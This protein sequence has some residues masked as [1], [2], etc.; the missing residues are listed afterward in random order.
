MFRSFLSAAG[1][2]ALPFLGACVESTTEPASLTS[3]SITNLGL[4]SAPGE[5]AGQD[6]LWLFAAREFDTGGRDLNRDGD[7]LDRIVYVQDLGSG[8]ARSTGLALDTRGFAPQLAVGDDL[9]AFAASES[10]GGGTDLN[11]DGD[12]ND[13]V[14]FA[15]DGATG[16]VQ[17]LA[18]AV[19][20]LGPPAVGDGIAAVLVSEAAQGK[21]DL[22]GDGASDDDVLFVFDRGRRELLNARIAVSSPLFAGDGR[23]AYFQAESSTDLN[24]DGDLLDRAVLQVYDPATDT[25]FNTGLATIGSEPLEA[26]GAWLVSV[27]EFEQGFDLNADA[28]LDDVVFVVFD[29]RANFRLGGGAPPGLAPWTSLGLVSAG[30]FAAIVSSVPAGSE[31]FGLLALEAGDVDRNG[32]GDLVDLVAFLYDP[33]TDQL[34]STARAAVRI[35][36]AGEWLGFLQLESTGVSGD[37]PSPDL[38]G[39]GDLLDAVAC[40]LNPLT[41]GITNLKQDAFDLVGSEDDVLLLL[42]PESGSN[43]DWNGDGDRDD[44]V[45]HAYDRIARTTTN[46]LL[47]VAGAF[48]ATRSE[49]LLFADEADQSR[50]LDADGDRLDGVFVLYDLARKSSLNFSL[51]GSGPVPFAVLTSE[52]RVVLLANENA[53]GRDLNGDGDRGDE[54][55]HRAE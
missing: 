42:R 13:A 15:V 3:P 2:C 8:T 31:R 7:A 38:N 39:D 6:E 21:R 30:P 53:Q 24:G 10:A 1:A 49:L 28:D 51:A 37:G 47:A 12:A 44:V 48:G 14:L 52:G 40:L 54:V 36:F 20:L 5:L 18:V 19:A 46:T 9:G 17:G 23:V 16:A 26:A 41:G 33:S 29:A 27:A 45:A 50:D 25:N 4:A 34:T 22:D 55:F 32:D 43:V 35:V 11:G